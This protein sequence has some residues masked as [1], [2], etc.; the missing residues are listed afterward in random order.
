MENM[1]KAE[2]VHTEEE[3]F[4]ERVSEQK[5][6]LYGIAYNYLRSKPERW[7]CCRK[8]SRRKPGLMRGLDPSLSGRFS[9]LRFASPENDAG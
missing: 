2:A 4:F 9:G 8:R 7:K 6:T 3:V 1:L 5:R